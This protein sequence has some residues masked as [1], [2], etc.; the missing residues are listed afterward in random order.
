MAECVKEVALV[1][2]PG[3]G[4]TE[5]FLR[6]FSSK[7][8]G[9]RVPVSGGIE[10][11]RRCNLSCI[12]CYNYDRRQAP[13]PAHELDTEQWKRILDQVSDAGCLMLLIT[14]GEPLLR[15]DFPELYTHAVERGLLVSVFTNGI[16]VNERI[17]ELFTEL[18]PRAVEITLYGAS[19]ATYERITGSPRAREQCLRGVRRLLERGVRLTLKTV[20]MDATRDEFEAMRDLARSLGVSFRYDAAVFP[21]LTG[22]P[23]PL[24]YR[25]PAGEVVALEMADAGDRRWWA[26]YRERTRG[27]RLGDALYQCGA[28]L[29]GFHIDAD[30]NL[31]GCVMSRDPIFNLVRDG[32]FL[33][34]WN[35]AVAGLRARRPDESSYQCNDCGLRGICATCPALSRLENGSESRS[36]RYICETTHERGA[37]LEHA[38]GSGCGCGSSGAS[39][40]STRARGPA[41]TAPLIQLQVRQP[42]PTPA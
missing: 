32:D 19:D 37:V 5:S 28:G 23:R 18:P 9:Q 2:L 3:D 14:G 16:L 15:R 10:L 29:T 4:E 36:S 31:S 21:R 41:R 26:G 22:D 25:I 35:G 30:G 8:L 6:R 27:L 20:L 39:C 40:S 42:L 24:E 38:A 13:P 1:T 11:T 12:H 17:V 33:T 7:V 34:G